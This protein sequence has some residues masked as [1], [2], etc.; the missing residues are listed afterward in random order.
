MAL[1]GTNPEHLLTRLTT[2]SVAL[3]GLLHCLTTKG[4]LA[5]AD[6]TE[7]ELFA[8]DLARDLRAHTASGPQVAGARLEEDV[9]SFFAALR[10]DD[11]ADAGP[12]DT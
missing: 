6:V 10:P 7:I 5:P 2:V 12:G 8:L 9:R 3:Q 4:L 11:E 1:P